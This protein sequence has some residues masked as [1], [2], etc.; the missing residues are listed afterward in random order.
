MDKLPPHGGVV[1]KRI[2]SKTDK[3]LF[4]LLWKWARKRHGNKGRHWISRRYWK[5]EGNKHWVFKDTLTLLRFCDTK[6]RRHIP[7]KLEMNPYIDTEYF[8]K[9]R[10]RLLVNRTLGVILPETKNQGQT[11]S[12]PTDGGLLEA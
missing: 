1:A 10:H 12:C 5:T 7:L 9:R 2:F 8:H 3:E 6:V 4:L 11:G